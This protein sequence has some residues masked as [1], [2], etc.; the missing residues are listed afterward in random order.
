[1]RVDGGPQGMMRISNTLTPH[2]P[3]AAPHPRAAELMQEPDALFFGALMPFMLLLAV[4]GMAE[5]V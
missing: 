3:T 4:V 1:M 2:T 5:R